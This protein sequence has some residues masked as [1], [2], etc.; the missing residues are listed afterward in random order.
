MK[1]D[2]GVELRKEN[3]D[4]TLFGNITWNLNSQIMYVISVKSRYAAA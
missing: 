1:G 3:A 4:L 2:E